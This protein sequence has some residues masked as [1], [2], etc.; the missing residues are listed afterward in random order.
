MNADTTPSPVGRTL[1]TDH[2]TRNPETTGT[3]TVEVLTYEPEVSTG[4]GEP[5]EMAHVSLDYESG[6]GEVEQTTYAQVVAVAPQLRHFRASEP[7]TWVRE[8]WANEADED[9][10]LVRSHN[11]HNEL[12]R[13][14]TTEAI[15]WDDLLDEVEQNAYL[16]IF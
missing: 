15:G 6:C 11:S 2:S 3:L 16:V 4:F 9:G 7:K 14:S 1:T 12:F 13:F 10:E 5:A 8:A